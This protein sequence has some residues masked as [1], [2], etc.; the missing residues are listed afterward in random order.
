MPD[1]MQVLTVEV[2][3]GPGRAEAMRLFRLTAPA[4]V[5]VESVCYVQN[6]ALWYLFALKRQM[7]LMGEKSAQRYERR[8]F[9]G[10]P[11]DPVPKIAA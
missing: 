10:C 9:H 11:S 4:S 5:H 2:P 7:V 3:D 8:L 1:P 6:L